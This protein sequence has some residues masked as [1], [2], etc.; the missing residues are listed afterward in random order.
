M[1]LFGCVAYVQSEKR[2]KLDPKA[3]KCYFIWYGSEKYGYRCCTSEKTPPDAVK[4]DLYDAVLVHIRWVRS[5]LQ[6]FTDAVQ[7]RI[8]KDLM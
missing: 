2:D 5:S 3:V 1:K 4:I 7:N 6:P 8:R